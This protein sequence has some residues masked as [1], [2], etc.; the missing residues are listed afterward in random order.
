MIIDRVTRKERVKE[1]MPRQK[2]DTDL[3][4]SLRGE[5]LALHLADMTDLNISKTLKVNPGMVNA[6]W[7]RAEVGFITGSTYLGGS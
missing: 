7:N 1:A 5:I 6:I 3:P 4:I 2:G